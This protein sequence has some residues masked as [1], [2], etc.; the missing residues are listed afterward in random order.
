MFF[1][2]S[3]ITF[4]PDMSEFHSVSRNPHLTSLRHIIGNMSRRHVETVL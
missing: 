1:K 3:T 2:N 4:A